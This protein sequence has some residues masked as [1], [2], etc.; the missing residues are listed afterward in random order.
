M[1]EGLEKLRGEE[2]DGCMGGMRRER[3]ETHRCMLRKESLGLD[4]GRDSDELRVL[5]TMRGFLL[6]IDVKEKGLHTIK[7]L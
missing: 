2:N 1:G 6:G 4:N 3:A 7:F 5:R